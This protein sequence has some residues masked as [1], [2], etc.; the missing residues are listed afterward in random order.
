[1]V[2]MGMWRMS[3]THQVLLRRHA[4]WYMGH[5]HV[6]HVAHMG[7]DVVGHIRVIGLHV[8]GGHCVVGDV[9][10]RIIRI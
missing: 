4:I 8:R 10:H 6:L 1:M 3:R 2:G 7:R 5:V 9:W